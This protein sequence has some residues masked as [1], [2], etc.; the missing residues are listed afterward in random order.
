MAILMQGLVL[1]MA[2]MGIVNLFLMLLV[3]VMNRATLVV[4]HFNYILPDEAPKK[5]PLLAT[6]HVI[7]SDDVLIAIAVATAEARTA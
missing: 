7:H 5:K 6:Q 3:W 1:L 2:G 4:A